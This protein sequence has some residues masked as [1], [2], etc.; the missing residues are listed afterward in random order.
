MPIHIIFLLKSYLI[1][2][3]LDILDVNSCQ[4]KTCRYFLSCF[5]MSSHSVAYYLSVGNKVLLWG[6]LLGLFLLVFSVHLRFFG[7]KRISS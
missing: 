4:I 3:Y 2:S 5:R 6:N 7:N 1:L